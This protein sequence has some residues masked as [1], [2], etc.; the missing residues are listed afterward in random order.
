MAKYTVKQLKKGKFYIVPGLDI[1]LLRFV[2]CFVP[3]SLITK[4]VYYQQKKKND[5]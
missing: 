1:K 4:I 2:S 3:N 5:V